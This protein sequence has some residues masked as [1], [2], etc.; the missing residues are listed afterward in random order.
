MPEPILISSLSNPTVRH[1][2]RMRENRARRKA[3]RVIV[4][5]WRETAQALASGMNLVGV[6]HR[7]DSDIREDQSEALDAPWMLK[8]ID[9]V[10]VHGKTTWVTPSVLEKMGYGQ[11]QRG[12]VAE[13]QRPSRTMDQLPCF[14]GA[15]FPDAEGGRRPLVLVLDQIEKPGNVGA[16]FRSADAA[17]VDAVL[18]CD[19]GDPLHPNAI[20]SSSGGVFHVPWAQGTFDQIA[21]GL[22]AKSF[23][24]LTARV[25][26]SLS[27]WSTDWSGAMAVVV[28]NEAEGLASRWT[29]VG[30][31]RT[32]GIRIP[33]AG[34]VDSLNVSVAAAV[35]VLTA[36]SARHT[37]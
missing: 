31:H 16:I 7:P 13:F 29:T 34:Q 20:R 36:A 35:I 33:M 2:V 8:V 24:V 11:S 1:L 9:S 32:E 3:G 22:A 5:G 28:G 4:D 10:A 17:G 30:G 14:S 26:S 15:S 27:L 37:P 21:E 23:R 25:E 19:G 12:V 18:M 6:Y